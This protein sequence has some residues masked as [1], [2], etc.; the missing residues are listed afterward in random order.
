MISSCSAWTVATMSRIRPVWARSRAAS[1]TLGPAR[2]ERLGPPVPSPCAN[3]SSSRSIDPAAVGK[4]MAAPAQPHRSR[5]GGPVERL[6]DGRPPVH[7]EGFV[8]GVRDRQAADVKALVLAIACSASARP[9][10]P[11]PWSAPRSG[12]CSG[13]AGAFG[14]VV[15]SGPVDATENQRLPPE[16]EL[17]ETVQ[18]VP[19]PDI[20]L[21]E[22][23]ESA[24]PVP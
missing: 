7:D 24:A 23:L 9:S 6:G 10:G 1:S 13:I 18:A 11:G 19:H 17:L 20:A 12:L 15:R 16:L 8:L 21:G 14:P 3:S 2:P 5:P 4:E 22:G